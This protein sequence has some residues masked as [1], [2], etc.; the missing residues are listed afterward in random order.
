MYAVNVTVPDEIASDDELGYFD[1][2]FSQEKKREKNHQSFV[3]RV[4]RVMG[5]LICK[6]KSTHDDRGRKLHSSYEEIRKIRKIV[7]G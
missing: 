2:T 6:R 1:Q 4:Q 5:E 7:W 3:Y